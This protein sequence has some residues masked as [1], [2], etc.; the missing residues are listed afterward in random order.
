[1]KEDTAV[2]FSRIVFKERRERYDTDGVPKGFYLGGG[3]V[4]GGV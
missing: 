2:A 4:A 3:S 1:M